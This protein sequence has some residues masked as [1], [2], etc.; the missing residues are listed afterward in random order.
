[1][2]RLLESGGLSVNEI[3]TVMTRVKSS[4]SRMVKILI[5][6]G[7]LPRSVPETD[8]RAVFINL[9]CGGAKGYGSD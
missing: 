5:R 1:M 6:D 7:L 2:I 3:A 9:T 4:V 8:L